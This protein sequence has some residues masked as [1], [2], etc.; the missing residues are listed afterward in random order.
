MK[1]SSPFLCAARTPLTFH[2]T[3]FIRA[4][5]RAPS[6]E[7]N[8]FRTAGAVWRTFNGQHSTLNVQLDQ[9]DGREADK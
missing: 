4:V 8:P 3:I 9:P 7:G 1:S 2:E 6:P 5:Q